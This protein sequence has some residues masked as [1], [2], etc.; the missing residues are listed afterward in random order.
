M[1]NDISGGE[2]DSMLAL[3]AVDLSSRVCAQIGLKLKLKNN[4]YFLLLR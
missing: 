1:Y 3:S 4:W 2:M